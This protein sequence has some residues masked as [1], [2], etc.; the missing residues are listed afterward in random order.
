VLTTTASTSE[1][2]KVYVFDLDG[3]MY[4]GSEPVVYAAETLERLRAR[5]DKPRLYFLTNNSSQT[6]AHYREKLTAM[7]MPCEEEE[8]VTSASATAAYLRLHHDAV[9]KR[10]LAVGGIGIVDELTRAGIATERAGDTEAREGERF[11]FVVVGMDR[12][13]D[14]ERLYRAQQAILGGALFVATNRDGQYPLEGGRVV[15]GGGS[16]VAAVQAAAD[17]V[18]LV[19]GKPEPYGLQTILDLAGVAP[20]EAV[21][22]GDRL[23]TDVLCGNRLNVP[24]VLVLTGVTTRERA[25]ALAA[26]DP[27]LAPGRIIEDLRDL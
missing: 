15:P 9:G 3:V 19:I 25:E 8:I 20:S 27:A 23:D 22:V 13:F 6:R 11:D 18:P 5:A 14:Y 4:R 10:A 16:M 2:P 7:G 21:M 24:T 26:A 12:D 17:A 1:F